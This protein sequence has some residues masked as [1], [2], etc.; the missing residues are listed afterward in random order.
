MI[1]AKEKAIL[2]AIG[3]RIRQIREAKG[4]SVYDITGDELPIKDRQHWQRIEGG[5]NINLT[6]VY[7][8]AEALQVKAEELLR[9][10]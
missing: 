8:V 10:I 1:S 6:T 9:G 2:R 7:R 4:L 5:K 3:A